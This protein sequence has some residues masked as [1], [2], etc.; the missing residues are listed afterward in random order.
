MS[1]TI[2]QPYK[3][4]IIHCQVRRLPG[5]LPLGNEPPADIEVRFSVARPSDGAE[6]HRR[7]LGYDDDVDRALQWALEGGEAWIEDQLVPG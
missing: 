6:A 5:V 2:S 3:G 7:L 1:I 4:F